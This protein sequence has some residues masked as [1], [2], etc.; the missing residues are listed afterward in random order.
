MPTT[1][2]NYEAMVILNPIM[3]EDEINTLVDRLGGVLKNGGAN[4][5]EIARWG[6][7]KMAYEINKKAE[8]YY[9][10]YYFTLD[11]GEEVLTVFERTCRYDEQVMRHMVVKVPTK[12]KGQEV[13]QLVPAP[14]YLADFKLESRSHARR[15]FEHDRPAPFAP[16]SPAPVPVAEAA[17]APMPVT[18]PEPVPAPAEV[19]EEKPEA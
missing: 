6:K 4:M 12:K 3:S 15:R 9:V 13:A 18:V 7:R 10:I 1:I 19:A 8:G 14:G 2:R 17:P 5:R 16:S 11:G